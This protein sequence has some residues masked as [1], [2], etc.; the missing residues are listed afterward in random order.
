[1]RY[2]QLEHAI[3]A[4]CD[5]SGDTELFIFG[6]QAILGSFPDA[7]ESL[8]ASIEVD[9]QSK[10]RPEMTDYIDGALGQGSKFHTTHG[11]YVHGV[12]IDSATLPKGWPDRTIEVSHPIGTKG[13]KGLCIEAHDL[14]ASKL[15][16]HREKDRVFVAT[17]LNEGLIDWQTLLKRIDKLPVE[18]RFRERLIKWVEIM[19]VEISDIS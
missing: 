3:R 17:L 14:A 9:V 4:A 16:A 18:D 6:S 19:A 15:V 5:V 11:F 10:N 2:D 13:N 8:R 1:M 7:P 12:S